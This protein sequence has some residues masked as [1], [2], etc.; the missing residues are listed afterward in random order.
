[1]FTPKWWNS[2]LASERT[3][4]SSYVMARDSSRTRS[5]ASLP[6]TSAPSTATSTNESRAPMRATQLQRIDA[7]RAAQVHALQVPS[8]GGGCGHEALHNA[9]SS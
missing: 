1:M 8:D 5:P 4:K 7:A 2:A 9:A 6:N 3:L